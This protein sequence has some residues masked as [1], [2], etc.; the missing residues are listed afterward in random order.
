MKHELLTQQEME[1]FLAVGAQLSKLGEELSYK[2]K[3]GLSLPDLDISIP[4]VF[5]IDFSKVSTKTGADYRG[6]D[7][8]INPDLELTPPIYVRLKID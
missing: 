7:F 8:K 5:K 4:E 3:D 1:K 2:L 6:W